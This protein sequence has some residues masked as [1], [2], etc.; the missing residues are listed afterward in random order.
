VDQI[1]LTEDAVALD[2]DEFARRRDRG[3]WAGAAELVAGAFLEGLSVPGASE[4][5]TWL[6]AERA[7][8]RSQSGEALVRWSERQLAAGDAVAAAA[9]AQRALALDAA[10]EPAACAA[11]RALA[12]AGDRAGAL[13]VFEATTHALAEQLGT[14]PAPDT[15]RLADRVR[16]ARMGRR[17]LHAP[18]GARPRP[19]VVG[20]AVELA[21]VAAAWE[22]ARAGRGQV[23]LVDGEPGEGKTRLVEELV[24]RALLDAASVA[25]AR[26][27]PTDE[28]QA[29]SGV[30]GLLAG[31]L[32]DAPGLSAAPPAALAAL[33]A[34]HPD[35]AARFPGTEAALPV[36]DALRAAVIAAAHERPLLLALDDAQW[37]DASTA[38][39]L[40]ALAR[41]VAAR[42]VALVLGVTWGAPGAARLDDLRARLGRDLEGDAIRLARFDDAALRALVAWALPA[43]S[44]QDADRLVRRLASDTA[45]IP[46]LAVAVLEAVAQGL[47]LAADAPAWPTPARTLVDSLPGDLPPAVV[48]A[49]CLQYRRLGPDAQQVLAAAAALDGRVEAAT[50]ARATTLAAAAVQ[51]ALDE[52]EWAAWLGCDA[53]GYAFAAPIARAVL[54]QEMLTPGQV[55][56]LR[57]ARET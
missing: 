14:R 52:L 3:D 13:R 53:R 47:R 54:L 24:S 29:W 34:L 23:V 30:A 20:R 19:P 35:L 46:L 42:P 39:V 40:P 56:R 22:R 8:W 17:V 9:T 15:E 44:P 18:A 10:A 11:M 16:D 49:L 51:A 43:Y 2:C 12:L 36:A 33:G 1:R 48:G 4:F 21:A 7:T 28:A 26:A 6:A 25:V 37:L 41:D 57:A 45:G 31:G 32:A 38:A 5:E 27:V 55:R 50:L